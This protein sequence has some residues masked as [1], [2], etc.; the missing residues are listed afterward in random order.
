MERD[1]ARPKESIHACGS[2]RLKEQRQKRNVQGSRA[3]YGGVWS[4]LTDPE[5]AE[6][7]VKGGARNPESAIGP[8]V[9]P[10]RI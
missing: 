1:G 6:R 4:P 2:I 8:H 10:C 3:E 9:I 7:D 5:Q